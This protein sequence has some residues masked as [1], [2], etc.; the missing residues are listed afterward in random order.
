[1]QSKCSQ[2][3]VKMV[4]KMQLKSSQNTVNI[5]VKMQLKSTQNVVKMQSKCAQNF[6]SSLPD[7]IVVEL[8]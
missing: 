1:M 7:L 8:P 3:A 2:N 5:V 4:V 6:G